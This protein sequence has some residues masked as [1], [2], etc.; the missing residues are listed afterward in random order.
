[1]TPR[2]LYSVLVL[3]ICVERALELRLSRRNAAWAFSQ[4]AVEVG[5]GHDPAMVGLAGLGLARGLR[6]RAIGTL[7]RRWTTRVL[8]LPDATPFGARHV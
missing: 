7:G 2:V 6:F 1:M 5:R 3:A 4:G 8:V